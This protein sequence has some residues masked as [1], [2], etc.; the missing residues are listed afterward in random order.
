MP[1]GIMGTGPPPK[2][3][4]PYCGNITGMAPTSPGPLCQPCASGGPAGICARAIHI[5]WKAAFQRACATMTRQACTCLP[6]PC[7]ACKGALWQPCLWLPPPCA[8]YTGSTVA[9]LL[10]AATTVCSIYWEHCEEL[11]VAGAPAVSRGGTAA[12]A[13]AEVGRH[14]AQGHQT[15][16]SPVLST[17]L[18]VYHRYARRH[19]ALPLSC[20]AAHTQAEARTLT[21]LR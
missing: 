5:A 2:G 17:T 21:G 6:P 4:S 1:C 16:W 13:L 7:A 8:A 11:E 9:S 15:Y 3:S 12:G 10:V 19:K 14:S 20:T 18:S